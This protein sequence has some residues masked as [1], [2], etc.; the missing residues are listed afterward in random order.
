MTRKPDLYERFLKPAVARG[1]GKPT[2][3][4]PRSSRRARAGRQPGRVGTKPIT[5][6]LPKNVRDQLK[7]L[8]VKEDTSMQNLVAEAFND[9][10]AK[11]GMPEIV[12]TSRKRR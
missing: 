6:H 4:A 2:G 10:F 5:V 11:H 3:G 12:P 1:T 8:A 9:F 7:I